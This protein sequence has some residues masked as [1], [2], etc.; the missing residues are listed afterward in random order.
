MFG[1]FNKNNNESNTSFSVEWMPQIQ[2][3]QQRFFDFL[4]KIEIRMQELAEA[5]IPELTEMRNSTEESFKMDFHRMKSGID[6]QL[7][8]IRKKV[9]DVHDDKILDVYHEIKHNYS[10]KDKDRDV[11][12]TFRT[13]CRNRYNIFEEKYQAARN[14]VDATDYEDFE[15]AYQKVLDEYATIKDKFHCKQCG[16]PIS[17]E[18]I[19]FINVHLNCS[20]CQTQNTFEPSTQARM[21]QHFAQDLA[22]Q[23]ASDLYEKYE[24]ESEKERFYYHEM[25]PLK[26]SLNFEKDSKIK[27]ETESKIADLK[28]K[29]QESIKN[30]PLFKI[31]YLQKKFAEWKKITPDLADHLET[32][33]QNELTSIY[34]N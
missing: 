23:R 13:D 28:A 18:K 32:R 2:E 33:L 27:A 22:H 17:I 5:A 9:Y 25:H 12:D 29:R 34:N 24:K 19:F 30:T 3:N 15:I 26:L 8:N 14:A 10:P 7:E 1:L 20:S 31:D 6:G 21:L 16:S 4:D 11:L